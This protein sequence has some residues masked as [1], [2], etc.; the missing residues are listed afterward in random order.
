MSETGAPKPYPKW[1]PA[2]LDYVPLL[3]FF[4][5]Y[6]LFG[7]LA[8]TAIFMVAITIAVALSKFV[9]G[10]VSPM[11]WLSAILVL[12]FGGLTLYTGNIAYIQ[13]KPTIIYLIL[14][15]ILFGGV[16][17][18]KPT[19]KYV[20]EHGYDGLS[21]T[22]WRL[23][24]RNWAWFFLAMALANYVAVRIFPAHSDTDPNFGSWLGIKI[25]GFTGASMIFAIANMPMLLRHGLAEDSK[26]G[27]EKAA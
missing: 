7:V 18:G 5:G 20:L 8:G 26:K 1:L 21:E 14:S 11:T 19:L 3:V 16:L 12:V 15:L 13:M 6:K 23:L 17:L 10:R 22:G 27:D 4:G 9:V 24:T 25:W 2:A